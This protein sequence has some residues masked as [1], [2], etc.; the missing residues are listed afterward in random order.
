VAYSA[1]LL[2]NSEVLTESMLDMFFFRHSLDIRNY[3]IIFNACYSYLFVI[4]YRLVI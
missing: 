4:L 2:I 3:D 1:I